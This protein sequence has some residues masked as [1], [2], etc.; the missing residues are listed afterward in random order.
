MRFLPPFWCFDGLDG[1]IHRNFP[2]FQI[3]ERM[4]QPDDF[5]EVTYLPPRQRRQRDQSEGE[6]LQVWVGEQ[7]FSRITQIAGACSGWQGLGI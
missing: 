5:S 6:S 2:I 7:Q 1:F 3:F 4:F